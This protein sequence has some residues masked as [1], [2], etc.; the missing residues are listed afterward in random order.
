MYCSGLYTCINS[1]FKSD[2]SYIG[3]VNQRTVSHSDGGGTMGF[4]N[5]SIFSN[6]NNID[7][8]LTRYYGGYGLNVC[9]TTGDDTCIITCYGMSYACINVNSANSEYNVYKVC[10]DGDDQ[11]CQVTKDII[12]NDKFS[13]GYLATQLNSLLKD[14]YNYALLPIYINGLC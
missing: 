4:Y 13:Y 1:V 10:N 7:I 11:L 9:C 12:L 5:A 3:L 8:S 6:H 14:E 2:S